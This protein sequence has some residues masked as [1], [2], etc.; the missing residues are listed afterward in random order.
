[1]FSYRLR[2]Y[3]RGIKNLRKLIRAAEQEADEA[4]NRKA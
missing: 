4:L 1:V 3:L 2:L